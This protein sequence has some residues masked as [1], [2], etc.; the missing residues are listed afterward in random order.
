MQKNNLQPTEKILVK[1]TLIAKLREVEIIM[2]Q[3]LVFG[4]LDNHGDSESSECT[5]IY[6]TPLQVI[7]I[8]FNNK[9]KF[10][11]KKLEKFQ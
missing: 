1:S 5:G 11:N 7:F 6:Y 3:F 2:I 8:N 10:R 9:D 4:H